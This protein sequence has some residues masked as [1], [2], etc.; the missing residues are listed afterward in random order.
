M[1][2]GEHH[3][4]RP[5]EASKPSWCPP[6][7]VGRVAPPDV[8]LSQH[9]AGNSAWPRD[10]PN[11]R[12]DDEIGHGAKEA[13]EQDGRI[14]REHGVIEERAAPVVVRPQMQREPE[15]LRHVVEERRREVAGNESYDE[16]CNKEHSCCGLA[17]EL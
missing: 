15:M 6:T 16:S 17:G 4:E 10:V 13:I 12:R 1:V 8:D 3:G 14:R 2:L 9:E 7:K 11:Q 5:Q